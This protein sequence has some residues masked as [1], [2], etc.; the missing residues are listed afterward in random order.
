VNNLR[1]QYNGRTVLIAGGMGFIGSNLARSLV[2]MGV[3]VIVVDALLPEQGG[4]PFN[5]HGIADKLKFVRADIGS[6]YVANHL[7][8]GVDI[9][10]NLAGHMSHLDSLLYPHRDLE[11]NCA[12]Q[13]T[14]LEACR[15]YNRSCYLSVKHIAWLRWILMAFISWRLSTTIF[16]ITDCMALAPYVFV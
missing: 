4:N 7:V 10:F 12:A 14:L 16:F 5:L 6:D 11:L 9:I 3:E 1:S 8:S 13:L 2:Q 15:C